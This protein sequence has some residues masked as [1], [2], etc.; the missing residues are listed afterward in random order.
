VPDPVPKHPHGPLDVRGHEAGEVDRGVEAAAGQRAVEL[1][2]GAVAMEALD[3]FAE[4]I[5]E[6]PPVEDGDRVAACQQPPDE[7]VAD[8]AVP[9]DDEDV[10]ETASVAR[11]AAGT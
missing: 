2:R 7:V 5:G 11:R 3:S 4:G 9:P 8:E 1:L 10:Q 6:G